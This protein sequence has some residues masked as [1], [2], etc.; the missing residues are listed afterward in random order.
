MADVVLTLLT[1]PETAPT[2]LAAA[3]CLAVLLGGARIEALVMRVPPISTILV[4]EEVLTEAQ[5]QKIRA[6][7]HER[8][9]AVHRGFE[10][11]VIER[12]AIETWATR[13]GGTNAPRWIDEEGLPEALVKK[14]GERADYI[15]VGQPMAHSDGSEYDALYAA[16]FASERP[17]LMVP[18]QAKAA[19]GKSVA[20]AWREDKFT[21][22]AVMEALHC[23]PQSA[24][25]HVLMG[26]RERASHPQIPDVLVEHGVK[27]TGHEL[28]VGQ[29]VF[30][31]LLL[32]KAHELHAD[33][34][35]MGAFVHSAWRNM[36][37]GGVTQ[38]ML[39][40]AD[41]PVLMRH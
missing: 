11:W 35:V 8:A 36:I 24:E 39:A 15:V 21:L 12:W 25:V 38:Y 40:H 26:R 30:G 32:A 7:E 2:V 31:A 28:P 4:T 33:L 37:F 6:R 14:W 34:L 10:A 22:H 9:T 19:F 1:R 16:L 29:D 27:V 41:I 17:V 3:E 23:I 20:V 5:E 18:A 13:H